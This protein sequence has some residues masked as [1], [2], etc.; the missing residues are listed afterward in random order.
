MQ[1][2]EVITFYINETSRTLEVSFRTHTD[3]DDEAREDFIELEEAKKFGYDFSN[4]KD[5][6]LFESEYEDDF[7]DGS[8]FDDDEVEEID[9]T[10]VENFL[11]EYYLIYPDKL[12]N[13]I[14]F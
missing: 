10:E 11:S 9:Y 13:P 6:K 2:K 7:S 12:P 5:E 8:I 4:S 1:I 3:S 14:I